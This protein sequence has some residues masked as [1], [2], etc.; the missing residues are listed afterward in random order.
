MTRRLFPPPQQRPA[1]LAQPD[2]ERGKPGAPSRRTLVIAAAGA[3]CSTWG[4][5]GLGSAHAQTPAG[6]TPA[7]PSAL[8]P[9]DT[10]AFRE[11]P[12][13]RA[14]LARFAGSAVPVEGGVQVDIPEL[15]ENGNAVPVTVQVDS[16]MSAADHVLA[17]ALFTGRNPLPEVAEFRLGP[18]NGVAR[19]STRIRLA[20]SQKV[21]AAAR[22]ADG[23]V[24]TR[25]VDVLVTLAACL[26]G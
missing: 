4:W 5:S 16:P 12:E 24:R 3:A 17:I 15:V 26:E 22:M 7:G 19:V 14:A 8:A 10:A 18:D 25:H 6:S 1:A 9:P 13:L 2:G 23:R 11:S 21:V 20:T